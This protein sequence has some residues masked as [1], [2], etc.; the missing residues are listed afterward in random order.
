M[1]YVSYEGGE[2][3]DPAWLED[4]SRMEDEVMMDMMIKEFAQSL[5]PKQ[6]D[7]FQRCLLG[8]V[9]LRE[10][11]REKGIS[12]QAISDIN[13]A[14]QKKFKKLYARYLANG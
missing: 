3:M 4:K 6:L 11:S 9:S 1:D 2:D 14:V 13:K 7:V 10:Y 5:T 8:G 12:N